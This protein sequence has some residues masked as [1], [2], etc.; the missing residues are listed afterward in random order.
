V[1]PDST[2]TVNA[3]GVIKRAALLFAILLSTLADGA[4]ARE[5]ANQKRF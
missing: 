4:P 2:L 1:K 3:G 5:F